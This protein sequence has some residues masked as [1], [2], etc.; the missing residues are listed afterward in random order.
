MEMERA[1]YHVLKVTEVEYMGYYEKLLELKKVRDSMID[2]KSRKIFDARIDY[3]IKRDE[4]CFYNVI[5]MIEDDWYCT[6]L[7]EALGKVDVKGIIIFGSGH[8]GK[9]TKRILE[10][11][12]YSPVYF[13]DSDSDK[14]GSNVGGIEVISVEEVTERY[15]EYLIVLGSTKYAEE[16]YDFL[17]EKKFMKEKILY[18]KH[19]VIWAKRGHQY[20]D[21]FL[22]ENET[23]FVDGGGYNGDTLFD[24]VDWTCGKYKKVYEFEPIVEMFQVIKTRVENESILKV[25]LYNNALWDK[26]Q[27]LFFIEAETG[28]HIAEAGR[29][30][31]KGISLDEIIKDEKVTYIKMDIEGSELKALKGAKSLIRKNKPKLAICIYHKPE[32]ILELPLYILELIPEYKFYIRH[33]SS[34]MCETVLYAEIPE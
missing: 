12:N 5:D 10:R 1:K 2:E 29:S 4:D 3:M 22:P 16:M 8:D 23:I 11:C 24:F 21:M 25:E 31:V 17:L 20:F 18:P 6:E 26:K 33:Y 15:Q 30:V 27:D 14:V 34:C 32:D 28:S 19:G 7:E 9:R 13:C